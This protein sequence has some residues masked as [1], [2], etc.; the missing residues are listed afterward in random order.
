MVRIVRGMGFGSYAE[1]RQYPHELTI[2]LATP[3]DLMPTGGPNSDFPPRLRV[4]LDRDLKNLQALG[5]AL[6]FKRIVQLAQR[7]YRARRIL[8]LGGDMAAALVGFLEWTLT[9]LGLPVS[10]AVSPGSRAQVPFLRG[11]TPRA[12]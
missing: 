2:V 5:H 3:L 12:L 9:I 7:L 1:F 11:H 4:W 8:I 10:S 6:D